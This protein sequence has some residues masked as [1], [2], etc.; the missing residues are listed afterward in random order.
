MNF[1]AVDLNRYLLLNLYKETPIRSYK[2]I[3]VSTLVPII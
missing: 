3:L 2:G 1:K